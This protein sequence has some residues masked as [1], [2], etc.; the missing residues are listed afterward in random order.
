MPPTPQKDSLTLLSGFESLKVTH[1]DGKQED[2]TVEVL[3]IA[4]YRTL[5]L[6]YGDECAEAEL[7]CGRP[8]GWAET[9]TNESVIEA[10]NIGHKLNDSFFESWGAR[11]KAAEAKLKAAIEPKKDSSSSPTTSQSS[12]PEPAS[13]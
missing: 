2:V 5:S 12:Q 3:H 8:A 1:R 7:F 4:K 10:Y 13:A 9:L 11:R 6:I